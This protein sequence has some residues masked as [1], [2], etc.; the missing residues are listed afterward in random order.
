MREVVF[1]NS[2]AVAAYGC[3]TALY[4]LFAGQASGEA[5]IVALSR[6]MREVV[7]FDYAGQADGFNA[8]RF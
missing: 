5:H 4:R 2:A 3:L 6:N 7:F 8:L 1:C